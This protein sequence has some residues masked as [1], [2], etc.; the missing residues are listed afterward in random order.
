[1]KSA[2]RITHLISF[3]LTLLLPIDAYTDTNYRQAKGIYFNFSSNSSLISVIDFYKSN[4]SLG[5][6]GN[7]SSNSSSLPPKENQIL[8]YGYELGVGYAVPIWQRGR[9]LLAGEIYLGYATASAYWPSGLGIFTEPVHMNVNTD[10]AN[11]TLSAN[12]AIS[13]NLFMMTRFRNNRLSLSDVL[14]MG[15]WTLY[16]NHKVNKDIWTI[17]SKYVSQD[18]WSISLSADYFK[19]NFYPVLQ[20]KKFIN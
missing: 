5:L 14:Y 11:I 19:R 13:D 4:Y 1:M 8:N 20:F 17:G 6:A 18:K 15:S 12:Y 3:V 10:V 2:R 7:N 9:L 16:E